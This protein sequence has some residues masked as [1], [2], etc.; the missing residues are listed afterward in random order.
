MG[1]LEII[2]GV[3][4]IVV[5]LVIIAAVT[6]QESKGGLGVIAGES[7]SFFD[8][9]RGKTKEAMLVRLTV[10]A[11]IALAVLTLLVLFAGL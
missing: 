3:L 7:G 6:A 1:I 4:L 9:N 5:C 8:K 11:G 10:I 2:G